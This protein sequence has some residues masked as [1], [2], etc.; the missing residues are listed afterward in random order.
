MGLLFL[1]GS[2]IITGKLNT[3]PSY[4]IHVQLPEERLLIAPSKS[5]IISCY[6]VS[7][8]LDGLFL[9]VKKLG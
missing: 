3:F 9:G 5:V 1:S 6:H 2:D 8:Q 4:C 7:S